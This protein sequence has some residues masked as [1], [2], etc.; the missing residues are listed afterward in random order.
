MLSSQ[1][2]SGLRFDLYVRPGAE[3]SG[4]LT[5]ARDADTRQYQGDPMM[6]T[7]RRGSMTLAE[8][9]ALLKAEG[10]YDAM[11]ALHRQQEEMCRKR[12]TSGRGRKCPLVEALAQCGCV[13][14]SVW[15]LVSSKAP[16]PAA[17]PVLLEH[18]SK[19]YPDRVREGI[20]RALARA[21]GTRRLVGALGGV[22]P[23]TGHDERDEDKWREVGDCARARR[24]GNR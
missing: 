23:R 18:L 19:P 3:L 15:D 16:Y 4:P 21:R 17:I 24:G 22:S 14:K 7:K 1:R 20:A 2:T 6:A 5:Q 13:V 9:D 11:Q 8:H 10:R 12:G